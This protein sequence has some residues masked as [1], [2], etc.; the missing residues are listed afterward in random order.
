MPKGTI[1][2]FH[3]WAFDYCCWNNW[4]K[5]LIPEFDVHLFNAGYF[6]SNIA[7]PSFPDN[8]GTRIIFTHSFGLHQCDSVLL[9]NT[10]LLVVFSGFLEFHPTAA[11]FRQRSKLVVR[12]MIQQFQTSPKAVLEQ[13]HQ[14]TFRP[15]DP[16]KRDFENINKQRLMDDLV[17][18]NQE[19]MSV[20]KL[21]KVD[22]ICILHGS[23]DAIVPRTKGRE[24]FEQLRSKSK[25]FE[26]KNA[27]HALPFTHFDKCKSLLKPELK[28]ELS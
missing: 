6:G 17:R 12:K 27:G 21:K 9:E 13:F 23:D 20:E 11:Q 16:P 14:N 2:C 4:E 25:Y 1:L 19:S 7:R 3:G 26:I 24:I 22:K 10:D 15:G 5:W 18:L 28:Q 8:E